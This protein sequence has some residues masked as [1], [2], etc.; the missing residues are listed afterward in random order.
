[1]RN[2]LPIVCQTYSKKTSKAW[3]NQ[4]FI[5][6]ENKAV[7]WSEKYFKKNIW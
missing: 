1:M 6:M 3:K 7:V 2:N 4:N 5:W